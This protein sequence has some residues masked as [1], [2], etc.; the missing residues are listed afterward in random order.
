MSD[1]KVNLLYVLKKRTGGNGLTAKHLEKS[2]PE[3]FK[4][5]DAHD[6][7][8]PEGTNVWILHKPTFYSETG[9]IANPTDF[10]MMRTEYCGK[11]PGIP[12]TNGWSY[13]NSSREKFKAFFP[14]IYDPGYSR[15]ENDIAVGYYYR[16]MRV[17]SNIA[18]EHFVE[19]LPKDVP[20]VTMGDYHCVF[21]HVY[22]GRNWIHTYD[23]S[24]M[25]SRTSHYF[26]Y[27][28]TDFI[29]PL[30]HTLLEAIQSGHRIISPKAEKRNFRDGIDDLLSCLH[31]DYDMR[32]IPENIGTKPESLSMDVWRPLM[33][34]IVG[35]GFR[36]PTYTRK[37][38]VDWMVENG[39]QDPLWK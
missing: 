24:V 16:D 19:T 33:E 35:T 15:L 21:E 2:Y 27:R 30:P 32:F 13:L 11:Y 14:T 36:K 26:Y 23:S 18:W 22:D 4:A 20:L 29:D 3:L 25:F 28:P 6:D 7:E 5:V 9:H 31:G 39:M 10:S 8:L 38:F 12:T 34:A 37:L 1:S 17:D